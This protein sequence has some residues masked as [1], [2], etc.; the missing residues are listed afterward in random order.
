MSINVSLYLDAQAQSI[1][2][3]ASEIIRFAAKAVSSKIPSIQIAYYPNRDMLAYAINV[4]KDQCLE[5]NLR[6]QEINLTKDDDLFK[7]AKHSNILYVAYGIHH[8]IELVRRLNWKREFFTDQ[9]INLVLMVNYEELVDLGNRAPDF[10]AFKNRFYIIKSRKLVIDKTFD[11]AKFEPDI[12]LPDIGISVERAEGLREMVFND[13]FEFSKSSSRFVVDLLSYAVDTRK[14]ELASRIIENYDQKWVG[15]NDSFNYLNYILR[16]SEYLHITGRTVEAIRDLKKIMISKEFSENDEYVVPILDKLIKLSLEN[17]D[18]QLARVYTRKLKLIAV[19]IQSQ[20]IIKNTDLLFAE[21][22]IAKKEYDKANN[23]I[24]SIGNLEDD[25][26]IRKAMFLHA[27]IH[28]AQG[29]PVKAVEM[30]EEYYAQLSEKNGSANFQRDLT[31]ARAYQN[32]GDYEKALNYLYSAILYV[33]NTMVNNTYLAALHFS[34]ARCAYY[35][36]NY[37][38]SETEISKTLNLQSEKQDNDLTAL[39]YDLLGS[40][41]EQRNNNEKALKNYEY[42]AGVA[43]NPEI[44]LNI[45][46]NIVKVCID[47]HHLE[48][49]IE[50][51]KQAIFDAEELK[52]LPF[53]HRAKLQRAMVLS[54]LDDNILAI[55]MLSECELYY[56]SIKD[57]NILTITLEQFGHLYFKLGDYNN[58]VIKF[59]LALDISKS[60]SDKSSTVYIMSY[61][62]D[63]LYLNGK[64]QK[65]IN[66]SK[67][68]LRIAFDLEDMSILSSQLV[69][70]SKFYLSNNNFRLVLAINELIDTKI[71]FILDEHEELEYQNILSLINARNNYLDMIYVSINREKIL[72]ASLGLDSEE[73]KL[74]T[75][76]I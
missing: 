40:I 70:L 66:I 14:T 68:A 35:A 75:G 10:W 26:L 29:N 76:K 51:S 43:K 73:L 25:A 22:C 18:T 63:S 8:Q 11:L 19:K 69:R 24:A 13:L 17:K 12:I 55:S 62:S 46:N 23:I 61:L 5:N 32:I 42:A 30:T 15:L 47:T 1:E 28:F 58:A 4:L 45:I 3:I 31:N 59:S 38:L 64:I 72:E 71:R 7:V 74:I 33:E 60:N 56:R 44:K 52:N 48:K 34:C 21:I 9:N 36:F 20:F 54:M 53:I 37:E 39:C 16:K 67:N 41:Y 2:K 50:L 57:T 65:A 49:A 6:M 27:Q